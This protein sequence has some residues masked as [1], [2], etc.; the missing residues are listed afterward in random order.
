MNTLIN[1][2]TLDTIQQ[3]KDFIQQLSFLLP[4][5]L[6]CLKPGRIAAVH[7]KNRIHYGSV[8]GLGFS[9]MHRFTHLVCD[10]MEAAGFHCMGFHYVPTDVV[11]E[12]NQTYRLGFGEMKKDATKMGAGIPEEIWIFRKA[13][14][15]NENA[16]ADD[17]VK[18][19][20]GYSLANWQLDA[21]CFGSQV[22]I[23]I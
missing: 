8:T 19:E 17:P 23:G 20:D 3:T 14:T 18:V 15:S 13:P 22:V 12:N 6:R 1:I 10:A 7:L 21:D 16:Y 4:E 11:A 2:T 5:M 9:V